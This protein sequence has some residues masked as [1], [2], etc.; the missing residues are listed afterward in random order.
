MNTI[1]FAGFQCLMMK[2]GILNL[3]LVFVNERH[4]SILSKQFNLTKYNVD[5]MDDHIWVMGTKSH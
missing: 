4:W 5:I 2:I 1:W 3:T